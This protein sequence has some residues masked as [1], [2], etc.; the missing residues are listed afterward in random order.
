MRTLR[1]SLRLPALLPSLP[2]SLLASLLVG[3]AACAVGDPGPAAPGS[4]AARRAA[5]LTELAAEAEAIQAKAREITS[6]ADE[7]R[8]ESTGTPEQRAARV[9]AVQALADEL[10]ARD[11]A[12]QQRLAALEAGLHTDAGDPAPPVPEEPRRR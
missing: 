6:M 5:E 8:R 11:A 4:A 1:R 2:A 12:L 3:L 10:V 9:A 7:A